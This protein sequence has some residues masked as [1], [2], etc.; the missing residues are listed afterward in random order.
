VS[1]D[2][3]S[4]PAVLFNISDPDD[5]VLLGFDAV[6]TS[7]WV[8]HQSSSLKKGTVCFSETCVST[9]ESTWRQNPEQHRHPHQRENLKS[10]IIDP[11]GS[12][13][14]TLPNGVQ[15]YFIST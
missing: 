11:V 15:P 14:F 3:G 6:K 8:I 9:Y 12:L 1:M 4:K 10:R 13:L 7:R 2:L 5:I